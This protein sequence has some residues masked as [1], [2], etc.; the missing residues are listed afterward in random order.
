MA[1]VRL[2]GFNF[3]TLLRSLE[4]NTRLSILRR[5]ATNKTIVVGSF[6]LDQGRGIDPS[7]K[8]VVF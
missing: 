5:D 8:G 4:E 3:L 1:E 6:A 7:G 2:K